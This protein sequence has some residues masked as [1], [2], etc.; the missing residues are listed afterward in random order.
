M[1]AVSLISRPVLMVALTG[2]VSG[3]TLSAQLPSKDQAPPARAK[4]EKPQPPDPPDMKNGTVTA[5]VTA[6]D[7]KPMMGALV[8]IQKNGKDERTAATGE[9]G[10][11]T[12]VWIKPGTY[13]VIVR[14]KGFKDVVQT[15]TVRG[16]QTTQIKAKLEKRG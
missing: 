3:L 7:D 15:I 1:S 8:L 4:P 14:A 16:A 5:S 12:I 10:F 13:T 9:G 11:V 2:L 6:E